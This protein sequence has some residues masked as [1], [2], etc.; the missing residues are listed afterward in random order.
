MT[1]IILLFAFMAISFLI[2]SYKNYYTIFLSTMVIAIAG[3][4]YSTLN[5]IYKT[6]RYSYTTAWGKADYLFLTLTKF[7]PD[8]NS[9]IRMYNI[10]MAM[11]MLSIVTFT[12]L[13]L[14]T[15]AGSGKLKFFLLFCI[16]CRS[17]PV[18]FYDQKVTYYFYIHFISAAVRRHI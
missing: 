2:L 6:G 11:F 17:F 15:A 1:Y 5:M 16:F 10:F 18:W 7:S 13:Y 8:Y 4:L 12:L 14:T 9:I 3:M